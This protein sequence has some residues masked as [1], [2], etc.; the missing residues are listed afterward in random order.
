MKNGSAI[1]IMFLIILTLS[2]V[3]PNG[4]ELS[5]GAEAPQRR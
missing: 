2:V 5:C 4:P 1:I 3:L